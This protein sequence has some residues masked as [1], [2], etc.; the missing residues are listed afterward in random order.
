LTHKIVDF[1]AITTHVL[2][3]KVFCEYV[4]QSTG[5]KIALLLI[6]PKSMEFG[7]GLSVEVEAGAQKIVVVLAGLLG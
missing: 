1:P 4:K 2:P 7:E 6:E 3:L 5:A